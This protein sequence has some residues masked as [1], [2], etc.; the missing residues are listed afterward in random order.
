[1]TKTEKPVR[2]KPIWTSILIVIGVACIAIGALGL[3]D[4]FSRTQTGATIPD[5]T[6]IISSDQAISEKKPDA[7]QDSYKVA[8]GQPRVIEIPK[9]NVS[10]YI[11]RVGVDSQNRMATPNNIHFA[12]WYVNGVSPGQDGLSIINGHAG[13]RYTD[14]I[15]KHLNDL[16]PNDS[17]RVQLGDLSWKDFIVVSNATYS[18]SESAA[19]LFKDDTSIDKELHLITCDGVFD[20]KTQTYDARTI[21]IARL[22]DA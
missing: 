15:F 4:Y 9:L 6:T 5:T 10:A 20:D 2:K 1:M 19:V 14:G 13:G 16:E 3:A 21:V 22:K 17:I 11:Q 12:G 7:I 8:A 18:E